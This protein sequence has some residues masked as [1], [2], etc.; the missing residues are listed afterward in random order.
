MARNQLATHTI[1]RLQDKCM[2][3][4][5]EIS[6]LRNEVQ[7]LRNGAMAL[8]TEN[9]DLRRDVQRLRAELPT[10]QTVQEANNLIQGLLCMYE[11]LEAEKD[12]RDSSLETGSASSASSSTTDLEQSLVCLAY[13]KDEA[14]SCKSE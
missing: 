13:L 14:E 6:N 5:I 7:V 3:L 12:G 8:L 10:P 2:S 11:R 1:T 9:A 4:E